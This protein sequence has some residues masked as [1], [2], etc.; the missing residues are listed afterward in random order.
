MTPSHSFV[1]LGLNFDK[2]FMTAKLSA[3]FAIL[4]GMII[5]VTSE[6]MNAKS[7]LAQKL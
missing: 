5:G 4:S 6:K 1:D 7:L 3:G 2:N